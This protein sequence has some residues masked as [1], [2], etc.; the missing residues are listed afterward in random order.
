[1]RSAGRSLVRRNPDRKKAAIVTFGCAKNLVDSEVMAG[2]LLAL[3]YSLIAEIGKADVLVLNTCGF[4]LPARE[5]ADGAIRAA[6]AEKAVRPDLEIVVTGCYVEKDGPELSRRFPGVDAW[7]GVKDY[8]RIAD[9]VEGRRF[10]HGRRTFLYDHRTPRARSTPP[11]WAYLKVSEG[12]SHACAFCTIP[13]I[14]GPYRS[15]PAASIVAEAQVLEEQGVKELVLISQDTT[16]YGRDRGQ[17][18]GLALLFL[19]LLR[20]TG[21]PWIRFLYGYPGEISD[22][23]LEAMSDPRVCPYFDLPFQH[24][25]ASILRRMRRATD[26]G[27]A[28]RLLEKIRKRLPEAAVRTSLI[29]G[30]PGEGPKEF[31]ELSAFVREARFDH[32]GVFTYCRENGTPAA[33]FG[34][35][36]TEAEKER[37]RAV[38]MEIQADVSASKLKAWTGRILEV[39]RDD[40]RPEAPGRLVGRTRFQAPEVDGA[41]FIRP[42]HRPWKSPLGRVKITSS[43]TYDLRGVFIP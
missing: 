3:G 26:A 22:A 24:A 1:M 33:A 7:L 8:G 41:V 11:G 6:L 37:R 34:E 25:A 27:R 2:R 9:A 19:K 21:L 18:D 42:T 23:L 32:L 35:T 30:F 38:L 15:R 5:E 31:A 14:K 39:V 10:R 12:C 36:V 43:G 40:P 20:N 4:I 16:F 28:L 17:R 13:S 29:V